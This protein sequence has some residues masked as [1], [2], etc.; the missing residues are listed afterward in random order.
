MSNIP[1]AFIK[2]HKE[3]LIIKF[4]YVPCSVSGNFFHTDGQTKCR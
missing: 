2:T 1:I 4:H 3:D